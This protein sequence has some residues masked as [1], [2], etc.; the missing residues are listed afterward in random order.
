MILAPTPSTFKP[1]AT[2]CC[3]TSSHISSKEVDKNIP[4]ALN[5]IQIF[6]KTPL[7]LT[8]LFN[9][10]QPKRFSFDWNIMFLL[11]EGNILFSTNSNK[12]SVV[13]TLISLKLKKIEEAKGAGPG[14]GHT[15]GYF[16]NCLKRYLP[17]THCL[18]LKNV[19]V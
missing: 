2:P 6:Q 9:L 16:G 15:F 7:L 11:K 13:C 4:K 14:G 3:P 19:R 5:L 8:P 1:L 12:F 17:K 10:F 18:F